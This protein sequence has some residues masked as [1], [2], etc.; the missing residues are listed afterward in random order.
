MDRSEPTNNPSLRYRIP[1]YPTQFLCAMAIVSVGPLLDSMMTDLGVSLSRGGLI[2]AGL[3]LGNVSGIVV[4]NTAMARVPVKRTLIGG[5]ILQGASLIAAGLAS[6]DLWTL[7]VT[8][9]FVGFGGALLNATCWMWQSAHMKKNAAAAALRMILFFGLAMM[10]VPLV[11]GMVLDA[12]AGWR[13]V[14]AVEGG[15]SLL[16]AAAI[17][18]L[19]LLD[20]PGRRN[21][22]ATQFK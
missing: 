20:V 19:P 9:L 10:I 4:L 13:W 5:A 8:Y 12:G 1:L 2:S 3:F 6:V 15:L 11:L 17:A 18:V 16:T 21:V 7:L 14:L 22:R